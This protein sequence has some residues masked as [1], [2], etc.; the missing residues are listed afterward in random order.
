MHPRQIG[1]YIL[2]WESGVPAVDHSQNSHHEILLQPKKRLEETKPTTVGIFW[3][4]RNAQATGD[5]E[6]DGT[7]TTEI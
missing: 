4:L 6:E 7:V 1:R 5:V 3:N 2:A